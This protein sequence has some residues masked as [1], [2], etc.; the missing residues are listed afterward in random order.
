MKATEGGATVV[1][2][3][4]GIETCEKDPCALA[5][6]LK[7]SGVNVSMHV[8]GFDVTGGA[9]QEL[10]CIAE[11]SGGRYFAA[12]NAGELLNALKTV[13]K[14]VIENEP[15]VI[16][17][18][19][20]TAEAKPEPEPITQTVSSSS[21]SIKIKA[22]GPGR[23][24]FKHHP[25]LQKPYYWRLVDPETGE[26]KGKFTGL[27]EQL[28]APG[29][30]QLE[31]HQT[32]HIS[33]K[34]TLG[35]VVT[36]ES[37]KKTE[38][39]LLTA[40]KLKLPTWVE[41][42][43]RYA[44]RE[45]GSSENIAWFKSFEPQ[46]VPPGEY[47]LVWHQAEHISEP[48]ALKTVTIEPDTENDVELTTAFA[49]VKADWVPEKLYYWALLEPESKKTIARFKNN[50]KPQL[51]P[52]GE[53]QL[54]YRQS[55]HGS[56]DSSVGMVTIAEDQMNEFALNTG[57]KFNHQPG[58][59]DPYRIE[60]VELAEDGSEKQTISIKNGW[61]PMP[62]KPATYKVN[63]HQKQHQSKKITIV[64]SFELPQGNLVEIDM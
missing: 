39:P 15:V 44:L 8:V 37:G 10:S 6:S 45:V 56:T 60:F 17:E 47:E 11:A 14:S 48:V 25:W 27:G 3:S 5:R 1:L 2:V 20:Q 18:E 51:V 49:V 42:P 30:Y 53:Y 35:E 23:I 64:D 63:Y 41:R 57:V 28:V 58:V 61:G 24:A 32:Q 19:P 16:K 36:I 62:L 52:A 4:D 22:K 50:Y 38:V 54:V 33:S 26:D 55:Q 46:L 9:A 29:T 34:V 59:D 43:T 12:S 13:E 21:T 40:L 31:W 7:E